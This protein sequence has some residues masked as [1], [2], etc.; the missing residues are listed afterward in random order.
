MAKQPLSHCSPLPCLPGGA[1]SWKLY[2]TLHR[3]CTAFVRRQSYAFMFRAIRR[4]VLP[5]I[6]GVAHAS[7]HAFGVPSTS[8]D[9]R[10]IWKALLYR[11]RWPV[12]SPQKLKKE[13]QLLLA[14]YAGKVIS[15]GRAIVIG[16][17]GMV[18]FKKKKRKTISIFNTQN[19]CFLSVRSTSA[20]VKWSNQEDRIPH[21]KWVAQFKLLQRCSGEGQVRGA[22]VHLNLSKWLNKYKHTL[23]GLHRVTRCS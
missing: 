11:L 8:I 15:S 2:E 16:G 21:T 14:N 10:V 20:T 3:V 9:K 5:L 6:H 13:K 23:K 1:A 18:R 12:W 22:K 4:Q 19:S 17:T 7:E